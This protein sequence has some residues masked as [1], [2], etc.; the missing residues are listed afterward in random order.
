MPPI[1]DRSDDRPTLAEHSVVVDATPAQPASSAGHAPREARE[2]QDIADKEV[3]PRE[4]HGWKWVLATVSILSS[5]FLYALDATVV[6]DIQPVIV[7]E[8]NS[9]ADLSWLSNAFL[10][11]ATATNMV[12]GR[13]YGQFNS[14]WFYIFNVALF[15]VGSALCG[16]APNMSAMIVGR[17]I[18]G[19]GGAGLYVGCMTLIAATTSMRERPLYVSGTGFTWGL[20][21]VL[22]PII[23]GAF[24]RSSVGW[25]WAFYINLFVGGVFAPAYVFLLP[26]IDP[27]PGVPFKNRASEM[28]YVGIVLQTGALTTF[29]LA[30]NWGGITYPWSS[31]TIIGLFAACGVLFLLLGIQQGWAIFATVQRRIIPVH[32]F[33]SRTILILFSVTAASGASAFIPIYFVPIFFQFTRGDSALMAGVRLLPLIMV[34]V[35]CVFVNGA[36][37][38]KL[39]YYMPWYTLGGS[40]TLVGA[41]LMYTVDQDTSEARIYGYLVIMGAGTGLWL[42]ASFAVAQAVVEPQDIPL[43]VGFCTLAQFLGITIA[44][45]IANSIYLNYSETKIAEVLTNVPSSEIKALMEGVSGSFLDTLTASQ[46]AQVLA[47]IVK[48]ISNTYLLVVAGASLVVVLSF[49]MKR[50]RLFASTGIGAT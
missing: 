9:I 23:G 36:L 18:C 15:E 29:F 14:K 2:K 43:A 38:T 39:G 19:I 16:A 12:W 30:L 24:D 49:F 8:F 28:D 34:M 31:G 41:A 44:L 46:K 21:I 45:A 32:F 50:E 47:V 26:S 1:E 10:L 27:R 20:G 33:R 6:A 11:T 4:I 3:S 7:K 40:L 48:A 25:R 22:G 13:I 5:I 17:A 42:Q 35:F 37:L